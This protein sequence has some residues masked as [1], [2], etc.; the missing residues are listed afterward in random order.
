MTL[1]QL[2][3]FIALAE[4]GSFAKTAAVVFLT[5]PALSR[6]I[7]AL[8]DE[9]GQA[10][11][12]RLG[13]R[14]ALTAFG[15]EA[16]RR[17][18]HLVAD[19]DALKQLAPRMV[20]GMSGHLRLGLGS[21]PGL[22]FSN[23]LLTHVAQHHPQLHLS[24]SRGNSAS[25]IQALRAQEL[26]AAWV[27]IRALRP[28]ADLQVSHSFEMPGGFMVRQGHPLLAHKQIRLNDVRQ[29]P[30]ASTPLSDEVARALIQTYGTEANPDDLFTLRSDETHHIVDVAKT[31]DAVV[32]TIF[33]AAQD[34]LQVLPMRPAFQGTARFG[35]VTLAGRQPAP[36]L[37]ILSQ[38][39][40]AWIAEVGGQWVD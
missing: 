35:L 24:L 38:N 10:L 6:S 5:Q 30:V 14:I 12:D 15:Q 37:H 17:A 3:H 36:P 26:D 31:S 8:E 29:Y 1:T 20:Q 2:R 27:D 33:A 21:G 34:A 4:Q 39:L 16:L 19:A 32:F 9:L 23:R 40:P 11:F 22:L 28:A 13:R 18:Q 25:L 7:Q